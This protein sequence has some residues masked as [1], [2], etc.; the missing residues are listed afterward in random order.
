MSK[1]PVALLHFL[2]GRTVPR[3][4]ERTVA[5]QKLGPRQ[6]RSRATVE[7]ILEAAT[8]VLEIAG[9]PGFNTN[10]IAE[11]AGVGVGS[12]YRYFPDKQAILVAL[13]R[14][15]KAQ[16]SARIAADSASR[17]AGIAADRHAIRTFLRAF[18]ER[19]K[20]RRAIVQVLL[21]QLSPT[22]LQAAFLQAESSMATRSE[23]K[24]DR[25]QL[26]VLSRALLGAMRAAVMEDAD[27][28]LAQEFE[29]ELVRLAW[30]YAAAGGTKRAN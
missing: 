4:N 30:A 2:P 7:A 1:A 23:I 25:V 20:A 13:G 12:I 19:T 29:D 17:P 11:R 3:V 9:E 18:G 16:V 8:Q 6:S 14:R 22:E 5:V 24:L 26:F 28:L 15:E 10:V 21:Q 27:F